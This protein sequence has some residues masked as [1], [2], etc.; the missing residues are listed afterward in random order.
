M[1]NSAFLERLSLKP[2]V[3]VFT[4]HGK[5]RTYKKTIEV[6]NDDI[7]SIFFN[8]TISNYFEIYFISTYF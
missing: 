1:K 6:K 8:L 4:Q 5:G 2:K 3:L 7:V